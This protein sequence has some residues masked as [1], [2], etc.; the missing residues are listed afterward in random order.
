MSQDPQICALDFW[1][2]VE[3]VIPMWRQISGIC[4]LTIEKPQESI[5]DQPFPKI[6]YI[7][8]PIFKLFDNRIPYIEIV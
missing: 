4:C 1:V 3:L 2:N 8:Y 7:G 5:V 6:P